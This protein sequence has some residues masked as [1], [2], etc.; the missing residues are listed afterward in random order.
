LKPGGLLSFL[1]IAVADG[2]SVEETARALD[3]GPEYIAAGDDYPALTDQAGFADIETIDVTDEYRATLDV[4]IRAWDAESI[5]L[6]WLLGVDEFDERQAR[7]RRA[8]SAI[9]EGLVRRYL[10]SA[11]R[12]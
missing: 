8:L 6:E 4:W 11:E 5:G 1:V 10:F 2:L 3:A 9:A 7:R 12:P